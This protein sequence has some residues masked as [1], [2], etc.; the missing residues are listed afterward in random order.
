MTDLPASLTC[1][2]YALVLPLDAGTIDTPGIALAMILV[3]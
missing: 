3:H 2:D 1:A